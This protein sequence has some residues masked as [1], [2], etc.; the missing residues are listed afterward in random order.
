MI[1]IVALSIALLNPCYRELLRNSLV[2]SHFSWTILSKGKIGVFPCDLWSANPSNARPHHRGSLPTPLYKQC[3]NVINLRVCLVNAKFFFYYQHQVFTERYKAMIVWRCW[4]N[5]HRWIKR[6]VTSVVTYPLLPVA[7]YY[8]KQLIYCCAMLSA[9]PFKS[10][11]L[12]YRQHRF[13]IFILFFV[14]SNLPT[15]KNLHFKTTTRQII[16]TF[17]RSVLFSFKF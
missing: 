7:K 9:P 8:T 15:T 5:P 3:V 14:Y 11:L 12:S 1:E 13:L 17:L 10:I 4:W 6:S 16:F 2:H